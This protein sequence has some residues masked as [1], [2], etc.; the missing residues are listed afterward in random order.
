MICMHIMGTL[1]VVSA[2]ELVVLIDSFTSDSESARPPS[3]LRGHAS[4]EE[5]VFNVTGRDIELYKRLPRETVIE[6]VPLAWEATR[7]TER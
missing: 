6:P 7:A 1:R 4:H 2:K 5:T 3:H